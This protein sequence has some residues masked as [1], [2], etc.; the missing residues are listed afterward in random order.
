MKKFDYKAE[1]LSSFGIL[2][3]DLTKYERILNEYG[4]EGYELVQILTANNK[5]IHIFKKELLCL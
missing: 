5:P 1:V 4:Q 3:Q 2:G